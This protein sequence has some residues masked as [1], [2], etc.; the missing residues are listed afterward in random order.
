[1]EVVEYD[2]E[3]AVITGLAEKYKDVVITDGASY[4]V[5]MK[6]LAEYR[7]LRLKIDAKHKE[8]KKGALEYGRA[9]DAEKKRLRGLLEPGENHLK[10]IRQEE[11]DRKAKIKAEKEAKERARVD[12]IR[13]KIDNIVRLGSVDI[14]S[15]DSGVIQDRLD[16]VVAI[17]ITEEEYMEFTEEASAAADNA[18]VNVKKALEARLEWEEKE[19]ARKKEEERLKK[20]REEQ[21]KEAERLEEENRKLEEKKAEVAKEEERKRIEKEAREK[22]ERELKE[23]EEAERLERERQEALRPDKERLLVYA[24]SLEHVIAPPLEDKKAIAILADAL[25]GLA[26]VVK[27]IR[28]EVKE[29]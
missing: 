26:H 7:E 8:L 13:S 27:N 11:D 2:I 28:T 25:E 16:Q 22:A 19:V 15:V 21:A 6:G 18:Y 12:G 4:K 9:V 3:T 17:E 20:Q 1:M 14:T 23:K 10:A 29:L 24:D 5:V